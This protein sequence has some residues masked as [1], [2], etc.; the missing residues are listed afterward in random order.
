MS[1][2]QVLI[3][4]LL[5]AYLAVL[6]LAAILLV[7]LM[8]LQH[9]QLLSV[10]SNSMVPAFGAGDAVLAVPA[11]A[12]WLHTGQVVSFASPSTGQVISHRIVALDRVRRQLTT[13]GDALDKPDTPISQAAVTGRVAIVLPLAGRAL[14]F[15]RRPIGLTLFLYLPALL[16]TVGEVRNLADHYGTGRYRLFSF[17]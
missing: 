14:D 13:R 10:Q 8:K 5:A 7:S 17:R 12:G 1:K 16:I 4:R 11:A 2:L 6:L 3:H 9:V 15:L